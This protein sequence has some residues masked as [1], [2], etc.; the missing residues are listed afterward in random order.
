MNRAIN[1]Y[2]TLAFYTEALEDQERCP[3]YASSVQ[4]P[5]WQCEFD[6]AEVSGVGTVA[7][8][9]IDMAGNDAQTLIVT[10]TETDDGKGYVDYKGG[11]I[12]SLDQGTYRIRLTT[13][14]A[15]YYSHPICVSD[16]YRSFCPLDNCADN[17]FRIF[18]SCTG[19]AGSYEFT[20]NSPASNPDLEKSITVDFGTGYKWIGSTSGTF[21]QDD[22]AGVGTLT[23]PVRYNVY[24]PDGSQFFKQY[25]LEFD[26]ANPCSTA[27][28]EFKNT[29]GRDYDNWCYL[30]FWN[31]NTLSDLGLFY[32]ANYKQRVYFHAAFSYPVAVTEETFLR[33]GENLQV[34]ETAAVAE[35]VVIDVYPIPD[36]MITVLQAVRYHDNVQLVS[37]ADG[38]T[39]TLE[40]FNFSA[41]TTEGDV[42]AIGQITAEINRVFLKGCQEDKT[43]VT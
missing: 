37:C 36:Y 23:I 42:C 14:D 25:E 17:G 26:T 33:N 10:K 7:G 18:Q 34:L 5:P 16:A 1:P 41:R 9:V 31:S 27:A 11:T 12:P 29:G 24:Y 21:D 8:E 30:E 4:L 40:N 20:L 6:I 35:Q 22:V 39:M 15:I 43:V 3:V 28:I 2:N 19:S 38:K 13:N 32:Q